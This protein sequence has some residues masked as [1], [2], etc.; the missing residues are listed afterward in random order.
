MPLVELISEV[1][2]KGVSAKGVLETY[3]D[4]LASLGNEFSILMDVPI[5]DIQE[6]GGKLLAT[7]IQR[8]REGSVTIA[9]GYDGEYGKVR[10]LTPED[11]KADSSQ[12]SLF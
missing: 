9:P 2:G 5:A 7:S 6:H 1:Q 10:M 12:T 11:R 3:H 8:M 4:L